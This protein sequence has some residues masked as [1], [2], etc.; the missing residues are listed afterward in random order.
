MKKP[1]YSVLAQKLAWEPPPNTPFVTQRDREIKHLLSLL[2]SGSG[3][4]MGTRFASRSTRNRIVLYGSWHH[5]D[6]NGFYCG[7]TDHKIIITPSLANGFNLR[8]TGKDRNDIKSYLHELFNHA[9]RQLVDEYPLS[10]EQYAALR[11]EAI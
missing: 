6:E 9:L 1:L 10:P 7:W 2:P 3:W 11:S 4:D 5:M 8:V